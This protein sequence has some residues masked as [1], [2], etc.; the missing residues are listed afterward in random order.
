MR[1]IENGASQEIFTFQRETDRPLSIAILIDVRAS[2]EL[3][4][5]SEK[6]AAREFVK[7]VLRKGKDEAAIISFT[8]EATVE[9]GL[10]D[11]AELLQKAIDR[12]QI[13]LPPA[14]IG[15]GVIVP[16]IYNPDPRAGSTAIWDAIWVTSEDLLS[17]T[18]D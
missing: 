8:G 1:G 16:P 3:T 18:H 14:Y 10:T 7:T 5:P 17:E 4:L 6:A 13:V 9:Q 11:N 12:V 15:G 2:E